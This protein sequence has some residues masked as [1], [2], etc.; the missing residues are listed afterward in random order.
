MATQYYNAIAH[1]TSPYVTV[2]GQDGDT[3]T[4][5][6]DPSTLPTGTGVG[7][8]WTADGT[9]LAVAHATSPYV[10]VYSRSGSTLTKIADPATLPA[11]TGRAVSWSPDGT[12][13]A[14][15]HS[16]TPYLT[17]YSRSGST[18]TKIA[19]PASLPGGT[20]QGVSWSLDGAYLAVA[21]GT[22]P[23]LAVY[24]RSGSTLTKIGD[25]ATLPTST[26]RAVS[27]SP[28]GTY[29]SVAHNSSPYV[30]VYSRSGSTL[31][32]IG[33]PATLPG[34]TGYSASW[35]PDGTY[36][37]VGHSTSPYLT[38]Y[39][40]SGSTLTKIADPA[41]SLP[42]T[43]FGVSWSP[44]GTYLSVAHYNSPYVTVYSRSGSTLTK[45]GDPATLPT[46]NGRS[47]SYSGHLNA[48]PTAPP[49]TAPAD[50]SYQNR[51]AALTLDWD[52]ADPDGSDTQSAYAL[53]KSVDGAA[54]EYWNAGTSAWV[55]A[56]VE[57]P[58]AT[59]SATLPIS[60]AVDGESV[61][62]KVKT[63]DAAGAAGP[64]GLALT[65]NAATADVPAIDAPATS[66][67]IT[68]SSADISWTVAAQAAYQI[69]VLSSADAELFSTGK[70]SGAVTEVTLGYVFTDGQTGLKVELTCWNAADVPGLDTNTGIAVSFT[71]PATPVLT[72]T[73]NAAGYVTIVIADPTP[74]GSQPTVDTHD[75]YVRVAAGGRQVGERTVGPADGIRISA[76]TV[77]TNGTFLDRAA[78]GN[79]DFEYRS[80]AVAGTASAY[81]AWT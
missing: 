42:N 50:N 8:S 68:G 53:S 28:D 81:S 18:L 21:V 52:F 38:V 12:Y 1:S 60:W 30:T 46:G 55:G 79:T 29:L 72:V 4:K 7:A 10:T 36:L 39:S 20:A 24:S 43:A 17:V 11:S 14:V 75:I 41:S 59:S 57:N 33:D 70:V 31:T 2:Y 6:S 51:D 13:L 54:L 22:S 25:P 69:R 62:F 27:W 35:S 76:G 78:A 77:P 15:A 80:L 61:D 48:A 45:I 67:T 44:D 3:S 73:A 65:V 56:E 26:G 66:A 23:Y 74:G 63:L 34:G 19:D 9:H 64:Y 58:T 5:I 71:P 47:G 40:R 37:S 16:T 32:K 49:W